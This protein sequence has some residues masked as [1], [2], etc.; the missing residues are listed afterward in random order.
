MNHYKNEPHAAVRWLE[1]RLTGL[2]GVLL[3]VLTLAFG[4]TGYLSP[5]SARLA[6]IGRAKSPHQGHCPEKMHNTSMP[7]FKSGRGHMP[8]W[9]EL[10]FFEIIELAAGAQYPF[11][12]VG[13]REK[14]I[15]GKGHCRLSIAG[16]VIEAEAGA[17]INVQATDALAVVEVLSETTL[18]RMCGHWGE[19][20]GGSGLFTV[21][22][23]EHPHDLGDAV[24][25]PKTTN[26]D[27]HY[28]DC[29]EYWILIEG[30]GT[31]VSEGQAY[32][33]NAGDCVATAAGTHHDFPQVAKL[34]KAIYFET[35]LVGQKRVGHL[36]EHT[37]G[38]AQPNAQPNL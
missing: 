14:V 30:Q 6:A 38:I 15:V 36:W 32:E 33:V 3:L 23:S 25:Y 20:L 5:G 21:S 9:C 28:H 13:P 11:A 22:T 2:S 24:P 4:F 16:R 27:S 29:D 26:F 34:V 31:A 7:V 8:A 12:W 17:N 18:V 1:S 37:H 19:V 35:T 10:T